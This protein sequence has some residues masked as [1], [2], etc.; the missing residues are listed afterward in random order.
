MPTH[1]GQAHRGPAVTVPCRCS[2][3]RRVHHTVHTWLVQPRGHPGLG[4]WT[5]RGWG[6]CRVRRDAPLGSR[7]SLAEQATWEAPRSAA[8]GGFL[9]SQQR[10]LCC[11]CLFQC[12]REDFSRSAMGAPA[13]LVSA[14][15]APRT[16]ASGT[17]HTQGTAG[18]L[19]TRRLRWVNCMRAPGHGAHAGSS[20]WVTYP[21]GA[22]GRT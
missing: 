22:S 18:S 19:W 2:G 10:V 12:H 7:Q 14:H 11:Q 9:G 17:A 21:P 16:S 4:M 13:V 8:W 3:T 6:V 5:G 1:R 15:R 20:S